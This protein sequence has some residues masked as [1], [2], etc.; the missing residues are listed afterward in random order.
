MTNNCSF[1]FKGVTA[2]QDFDV[3]SYLQIH[4]ISEERVLPF[5]NVEGVYFKESAEIESQEAKKKV[6]EKMVAGFESDAIDI[7]GKEEE[8]LCE[9]YEDSIRPKKPQYYCRDI[10]NLP[11]GMRKYFEELP[12]IGPVDR[13][14]IDGVDSVFGYVPYMYGNTS[15]HDEDRG[16]NSINMHL[17]GHP[18]IWLVVDHTMR[19]PMMESFAN[20]LKKSGIKKVCPQ[21]LHHKLYIISPALLQEWGINFAVF[22]QHEGDMV[23]IKGSAFHFVLSTNSSFAV[24]TNHTSL[25]WNEKIDVDIPV[26]KCAE[27]LNHDVERDR[28]VHCSQKESRIKWKI[29]T[30]KN[31]NFRFRSM[32]NYNA[33]CSKVHGQSAVKF[34]CDYCQKCFSKK[35]NLLRHIATHNEHSARVKIKCSICKKLVFDIKKHAKN[36]GVGISKECPTCKRIVSVNKFEQHVKNCQITCDICDKKFSATR[37]VTQHKKSKH[38]L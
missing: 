26:C 15:L 6:I 37:Y 35:H 33:H 27:S 17:L 25:S 9:F 5:K 4:S 24:A 10:P 38:Q 30:G 16:L 8:I 3:R 18:K 7:E 2:R 22:A 13:E 19:V 11:E 1:Q 36:H 29:C 31:C 34:K 12:K 23:L 28:S 32:K 14:E 20:H 21:Q